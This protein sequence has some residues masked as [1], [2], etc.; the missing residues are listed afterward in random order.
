[1]SSSEIKNDLKELLPPSE[2][3]DTDSDS[4]LLSDDILDSVYPV[5]PRSAPRSAS[6]GLRYQDYSTSG[7]NVNVDEALFL[8]KDISK[9]H[10]ELYNK[11]ITREDFELR[12][13]VSLF[14]SSPLHVSFLTTIISILQALDTN[15]EF[16]KGK[17]LSIKQEQE[18]YLKLVQGLYARMVRLHSTYSRQ[19]ALL[20]SVY[21]SLHQ[22]REAEQALTAE[23]AKLKATSSSARGGRVTG[24]VS[25]DAAST[26]LLKVHLQ[27]SNID[28]VLQVG[29][30]IP[31]PMGE[32]IV[33]KILPAE[34]KLVLQLPFGIL[35]AHLPRAVSWCS[36]ATVMVDCT[37]TLVQRHSLQG[38]QQHYHDTLQERLTLPPVE[39]AR[40]HSLVAQSQSLAQRVFEEEVANTDNDEASVSSEMEDGTQSVSEEVLPTAGSAESAET[41]E[42]ETSNSKSAGNNNRRGNGAGDVDHSRVFPMAFDSAAVLGRSVV[43][44]KLETEVGDKFSQYLLQTLPLAFAPAGSHFVFCISTSF[45]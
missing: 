28:V 17:F 29:Q 39:I 45:L 19:N 13:Q 40:I 7:N 2:D 3:N 5:Q 27:K 38:I 34:H 41:T 1:M 25:A 35:Y 6:D 20:H 4:S 37:N 26:P 8:L 30:A 23:S 33:A 21:S 14:Y 9:S 31:T 11:E 12:C 43:K 32:A 42:A 18:N 16:E 44:K 24:K 36:T 10:K 22:Q 15:L